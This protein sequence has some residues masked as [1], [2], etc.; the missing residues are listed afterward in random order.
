[1]IITARL[2]KIVF[3]NSE[4]GFMIGSFLI[5]DVLPYSLTAKGSMM[6]PQTGLTYKLTLQEEPPNKY[7]KQYKIVSYETILPMD[8]HGIFKYITRICKFVGAV[9][10]GTIVD[11]YGAE[12]LDIMKNDPERLAREI[13]GITYERAL[14][15]QDTLC[16]N[17]KNE[18]L[19]VELEA[20][21]DVP[22]MHKDISIKMISEFSSNAVEILKHDPYTLTMFPGIGF[23]L[24]DQVAIQK[25]GYDPQG[26]AR[27]KSV[28][29][30]CLRDEMAVTGSTWI[31]ERALIARMKELVDVPGLDSG[32]F[33]LEEKRVLVSISMVLNQIKTRLWSFETVHKQELRIAETIADFLHT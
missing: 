26:L 27:K 33:E 15:I 30:Y 28:A 8:P 23:I 3:Q 16:I 2:Q 5:E 17:E 24:A 1:M 10:G 31:P 20:I 22:G 11:M 6:N 21:L 12:T 18:R 25:V 7:G 4:T 29:L 13:N 14:E 19:M 9:T 32:L